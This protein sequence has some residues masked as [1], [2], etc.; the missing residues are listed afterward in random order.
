MEKIRRIKEKE[1]GEDKG[2]FPEKFR[3]EGGIETNNFYSA[4][5]FVYM[6]SYITKKAVSMGIA[7]AEGKTK[8]KKGSDCG[9]G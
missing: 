5:I 2:I 4:F 9:K 8:K 3:Y 7:N 6:P 1:S